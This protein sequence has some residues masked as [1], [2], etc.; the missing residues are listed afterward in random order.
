MA[1][2]LRGTKGSELTHEELDG[3]F[4]HLVEQD[5]LKLAKSAN[6]G[7]IADPAAARQNLGVQPYL[8]H[9]AITAALGI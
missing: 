1:I 9:L 7:D 5:T 8:D 6:L 4:T 2:V 3:N